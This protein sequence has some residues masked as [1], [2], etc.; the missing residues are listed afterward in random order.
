MEQI[1]IY[2]SLCCIYLKLTQYCKS[3]I[4]H[5]FKKVK[6]NLKFCTQQKYV[7]ET[8]C[9]K[10]GEILKFEKKLKELITNRSISKNKN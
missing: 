2:I 3:T 9:I 8:K 7:S 4:L 10:E 6:K 5:F 1:Y